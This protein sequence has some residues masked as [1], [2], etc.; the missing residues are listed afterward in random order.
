MYG[1]VNHTAWMRCH[2]KAIER[3]RL[4]R[5][6]VRLSIVALVLVVSFAGVAA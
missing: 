3:R 6:A 4:E 5:L 1:A 2:R